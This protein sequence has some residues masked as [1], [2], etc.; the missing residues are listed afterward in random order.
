MPSA[1]P[2]VDPSVEELRR[3]LAQE[4]RRFRGR[5]RVGSPGIG[6]SADPTSEIW[7]TRWAARTMTLRS[8]RFDPAA[9]GWRSWLYVMC[10]YA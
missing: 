8:S 6:L 1:I 7:A 3:E 2:S 9:A 10:G 5:G 4:H